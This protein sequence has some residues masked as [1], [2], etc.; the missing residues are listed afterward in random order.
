MK[1][2]KCSPYEMPTITHNRENSYYK[3]RYN[4]K[5]NIFDLRDTSYIVSL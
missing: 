3:N 1:S 5:H 4:L 2:F